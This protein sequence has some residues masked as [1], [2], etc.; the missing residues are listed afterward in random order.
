MG[1]GLQSLLRQ[2]EKSALILGETA[3]IAGIYD[4]ISQIK[5]N[6]KKFSGEKLKIY[7]CRAFIFSIVD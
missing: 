7:P 5:C 4:L 6:L 2:Q 3:L 1:Q